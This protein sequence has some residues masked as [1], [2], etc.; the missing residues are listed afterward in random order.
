MVKIESDW[1]QELSRALTGAAYCAKVIHT[2]YGRYG[3]ILEGGDNLGGV[4]GLVRSDLLWSPHP[5]VMWGQHNSN[6]EEGTPEEARKSICSFVCLE[7][8]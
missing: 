4:I 1:L 7:R 6:R 8:I 5:P 3:Q 2:E